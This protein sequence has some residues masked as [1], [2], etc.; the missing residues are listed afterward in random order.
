MTRVRL[1]LAGLGTFDRGTCVES[2]TKIR[3]AGTVTIL[4]IPRMSSNERRGDWGSGA[5]TGRRKGIRRASGK[6]R[7]GGDETFFRFVRV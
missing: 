6:I 7:S 3:H 4:K 5:R 2:V 1:A